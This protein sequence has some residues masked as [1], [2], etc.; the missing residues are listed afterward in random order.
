VS[1]P[2]TLLGHLADPAR[3]RVFAAV[4]LGDTNTRD[5][6]RRTGLPLREVLKGL[7]RLET[8]QLVRRG[9]NGWEARL[10]TLRDAVAA[11][12]PHRAYVDHGVA[13]P[14]EAAIL[15]TF[16]PDGVLVQIPAQ[17]SKRRVVLDQICRVFEPGQ[18]YQEAEVNAMLL[19]FHSDYAALRRYLVDEG[20]LSRGEGA[21][22]RSG[23]TIDI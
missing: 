4:L 17:L 5:L 19:A 20:F 22:W 10:E 12:S 14:D 18:R 3:L 6:E 16:M 7:A 9:E 1:D 15:R 13:D 23:G 21:Y 8:V 2:L 11:A